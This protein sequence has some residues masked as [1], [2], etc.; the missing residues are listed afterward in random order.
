MLCHPTQM[1][2]III[3]TQLGVPE[4]IDIRKLKFPEARGLNVNTD[5]SCVAH[6][7]FK[8]KECLPNLDNLKF[9]INI[10]L[11]SFSQGKA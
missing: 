3:V 4:K 6:T 7:G 1:I 9:H 8:K 5:V 2:I 11:S 10:H